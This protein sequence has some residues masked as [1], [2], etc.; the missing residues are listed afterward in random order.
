VERIIQRINGWKERM[1]S[2]SGKEVLLKA[3]AQAI[4]VY[5]MSFFSNPK[6]SL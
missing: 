6:R 3:L 5:V 2:V 1:L 4:P